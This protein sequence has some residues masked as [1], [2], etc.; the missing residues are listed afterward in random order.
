[1]Y[2]KADKQSLWQGRSDA[3]QD[4]YIYQIIQQLAIDELNPSSGFGLIGFASDEG[5]RRNLGRIG[6]KEGPDAI[7]CALASI[8]INKKLNLYDLGDVLCLDGD[9]ERAQNELAKIVKLTIDKGLL[10][11]VLGGG[12]ET[13][14]G[15]FLGIDQAYAAQEDIAIINFDAHLDLRSLMK[16]KYASSGT[17]FYQI[18]EHLKHNLRLFNYYCA[19][20]QPLANTT[21][22]FDYA[23][24]HQVKINLAETINA[25]PY[26][27]GFIETIINQHK[28]IYV[29]VCLDVFQAAIAPGVS[30]PQSMGIDTTYVVE[31][32][33]LL[34]VSNA[35]VGIDI[36][37]LS[38][39][40]DIDRRTAKL[41]A[42]LLSIFLM[43][44]H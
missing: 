3:N 33:K 44:Y 16:G 20:V 24:K 14:W 26:D 18:S 34:A 42:S 27:L 28:K 21:S 1:M 17:P 2:R 40:Y 37:E 39:R 13:A 5:I 11:I 22:L 10:P 23:K 41:A 29:S 9:L 30:A 25:N 12:H 8:A 43:A 36:V 6:A 7:R 32:L 31:A 15:H 19:G 4:E 35:V 38:P